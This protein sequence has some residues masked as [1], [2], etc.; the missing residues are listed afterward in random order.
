MNSFLHLQGLVQH[1]L[2][3]GTPYLQLT[4]SSTASVLEIPKVVPSCSHDFML[5]LH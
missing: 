4:E 2:V 1:E 5:R 3:R